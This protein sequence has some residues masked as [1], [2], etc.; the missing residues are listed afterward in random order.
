MISLCPFLK[1]DCKG[2][3]FFRTCKY[4]PQKI[5]CFFHFFKLKRYSDRN[6]RNNL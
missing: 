3:H 5:S 2:S 1:R 4:F 6:N